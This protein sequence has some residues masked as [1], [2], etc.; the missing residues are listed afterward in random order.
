[1]D[2]FEREERAER[3]RQEERKRRRLRLLEE[4]IRFEE[5]ALNGEAAARKLRLAAEVE[6]IVGPD[7]LGAFLFEKAAD[8]S[9]QRRPA[10]PRWPPTA[11]R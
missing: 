4:A 11:R 10:R 1:M 2:A 6:G 5:L 8:F 3:E 7:P 9:R